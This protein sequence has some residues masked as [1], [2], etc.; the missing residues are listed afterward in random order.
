MGPGTWEKQRNTVQYFWGVGRQMDSSQSTKAVAGVLQVHPNPQGQGWRGP[1]CLTLG[2]RESQEV[3]GMSFGAWGRD[4]SPA[5]VGRGRNQGRPAPLHLRMLPDCP[6]RGSVPAPPPAWR[7]GE[8]PGQGPLSLYAR[9]YA[10]P[11][12]CC[13]TRS[14]HPRSCWCPPR[15]GSSTRHS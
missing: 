7:C 1:H 9:D 12:G 13:W 4:H 8:A 5:G 6:C 2:N 11:A 10:P 15:A 3:R 14:R